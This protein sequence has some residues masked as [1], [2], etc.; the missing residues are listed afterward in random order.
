MKK[1]YYLAGPYSHPEEE[2]R[3]KR[4]RDLTHAAIKLFEYDLAIFSPIS[5]NG[6]STFLKYDLKTD[7]KTWEKLDKLFISRCDA[8]IVLTLDGWEKSVGVTAEIAY[9]N[10]LE[11][12]V[13]Y[14][15]LEQI[16]NKDIVEIQS[17]EVS[18]P[19]IA[20]IKLP[21]IRPPFYIEDEGVL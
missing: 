10:Q 13:I 14:K 16:E 9:A 12:P 17:I 4:Y 2:V 6:N 19:N 8:L 15:T 18:P 5:Y 1:L 20:R 3:I 11:M 21:T 7:W